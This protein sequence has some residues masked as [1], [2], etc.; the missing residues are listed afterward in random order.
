MFRFD[1][2]LCEQ[3]ADCMYMHTYMYVCWLVHL[4]HQ[5]DVMTSLIAVYSC[6][7]YTAAASVPRQQQDAVPGVR[8][9]LHGALH[10]QHVTAPP[11]LGHAHQGEGGSHG[12]YMCTF[13]VGYICTPCWCMSEYMYSSSSQ[14]TFVNSSSGA[15]VCARSS[16]RYMYMCM[17]VMSMHLYVYVYYMYILCL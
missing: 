17:Y 10:D 6:C 9:P 3:D 7:C 8:G 4:L 12:R 5:L 16:I 2:Q 11:Q 1:Y 14:Y 13:T 15:F